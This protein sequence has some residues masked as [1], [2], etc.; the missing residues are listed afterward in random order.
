MNTEIQP[1]VSIIVPCYNHEK[2]VTKTIESIV[3]QTYKNIEIIV[4]DDGSSD[5]CP[6]LLEALS[7]QYGF[8][9]EH[10]KNKGLPATLNK[11]IR[12]AKGEFISI[13][14]SDDIM[15]LDKI[16][17]MVNEFKNLDND[18]AVTCGDVKF[19]DSDGNEISINL[20]NFTLDTL[21][22][23][24]T[25]SMH[26]LD[27]LKKFGEYAKLIKDNHISAVSALI[28]KQ[29]LIDVGL[30]EE[31]I[32][33]EDWN[34]WLKLS[35]QYKFKYIDK[36]VAFYRV[37]DSNSITY[38]NA[39]LSMDKIKI[40]EREKHYCAEKRLLKTW[41][42]SYYEAI[43]FLL[44]SKQYDLFFKKIIQ[45]NLFLY[46]W[47]MLKKIIN[48]FKLLFGIRTNVSLPN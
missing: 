12:L 41:R 1:L 7:K 13:I 16:N 46:V 35:K 29:A 30:Y 34:M 3:N 28:K 45:N 38:L 33:I 39:R 36:V 40:L 5:N 22:S 9:Y 42:H 44:K 26:D 48:K 15:A 10:Q 43:R 21:V 19:I 20:Y 25:F 24:Q 31:Y 14:A 27:V 32:F 4:L 47:Y 23:C 17:L 8:Y 2:Y 18:Y 11:A 6:I 37:H